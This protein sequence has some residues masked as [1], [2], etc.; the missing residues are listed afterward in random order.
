MVLLLTVHVPWLGVTVP[1]VTLDGHGS[2]KVTDV[3]ASGP[4]LAT[5]MV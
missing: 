2:L 5:V 4:A 1:M 3:A